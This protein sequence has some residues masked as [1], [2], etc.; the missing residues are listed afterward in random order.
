[1]S[2]I[3]MIQV[4]NNE[5]NMSQIEYQQKNEIIKVVKAVEETELT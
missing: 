1:M 4:A 2:Q 3:T 5:T